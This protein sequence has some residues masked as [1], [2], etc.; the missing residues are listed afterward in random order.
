L[1]QYSAARAALSQVTTKFAD[2]PSG[3]LAQQRLDKMV[4]EKH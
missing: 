4:A 3:Q 1:K 2:T